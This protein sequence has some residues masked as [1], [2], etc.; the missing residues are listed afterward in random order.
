MARRKV[1]QEFGRRICHLA[2]CLFKRVLCPRRCRLDA[3]YLA[4]ILARGG[5]YLFDCGFGFQAP[6]GGDIAAHG[7]QPT[8]VRRGRAAKARGIGSGSE[9]TSGHRQRGR[10]DHVTLPTIREI[11]KKGDHRDSVGL[12]SSVA[13]TDHTRRGVQRNRRTATMQPMT[14][15][16]ATTARS[17]HAQGDTPGRTSNGVK[18]A[19]MK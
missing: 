13:P 17:C 18:T 5:F 11:P 10:S 12:G 8:P 1:G 14:P 7:V 4:N 9:A 16:S 19:V 2:S 6:E 15:Q 3:T